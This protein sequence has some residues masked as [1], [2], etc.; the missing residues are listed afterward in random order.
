MADTGLSPTSSR[1]LQDN[2]GWG[3]PAGPAPDWA[4]ATAAPTGV[5]SAPAPATV[6][7]ASGAALPAAVPST[8]AT[9][10]GGASSGADARHARGA[11]AVRES[12][13]AARSASARREGAGGTSHGHDATA[14]ATPVTDDSAVSD[15]DEVID[16]SGDVGRAVIEKVLG[17]R[18]VSETTD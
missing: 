7:E 6:G 9:G 1:S 3:S 8:T 12:F 11:S 4:T 18:V 15:D 13:A 2:A 16:Q 17:G 5:L 14:P 10:S